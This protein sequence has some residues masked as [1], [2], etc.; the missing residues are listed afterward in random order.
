ML[1][2]ELSQQKSICGKLNR[3]IAKL[4]SQ[5]SDKMLK[6]F[7]AII[8]FDE[9]EEEVLKKMLMNQSKSSKIKT[10]FDMSLE[11]IKKIPNVLINTNI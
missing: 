3:E 6:K 7:G 2:G 4:K 10:K 1:A 5:I 9:M 8:D 11:V